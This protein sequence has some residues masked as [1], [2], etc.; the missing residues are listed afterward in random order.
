MT[1][2]ST[3]AILG[4]IPGYN[5]GINPKRPEGPAP[6]QAAGFPT[7]WVYGLVGVVV[8]LAILKGR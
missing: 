2:R 8:V 7:M 3:Q 6:T 1:Q 5:G 4:R